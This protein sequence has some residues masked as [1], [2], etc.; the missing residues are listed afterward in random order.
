MK[1]HYIFL[2]QQNIQHMRAFSNQNQLE[3]EELQTEQSQ[4]K[5]PNIG[6]NLP[7][8]MHLITRAFQFIRLNL[9]IDPIPEWFSAGRGYTH[10]NVTGN[11]T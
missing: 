3:I 8:L 7:K 9:H 4:I 6:R 5:V 10:E 2:S 1:S 11:C